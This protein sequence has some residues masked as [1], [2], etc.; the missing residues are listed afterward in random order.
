MPYFSELKQDVQNRDLSAL[1]SSLQSFPRRATNYVGSRISIRTSIPVRLCIELTNRCNLNCPFC[2]VGQQE[3]KESTAHHEL[4]RDMGGMD[5]ELC[6]KIHKFSKL[7]S[8]VRKIL[9]FFLFWF[10]FSIDPCRI[11]NSLIFNCLTFE[12]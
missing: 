12:C 1:I 2:L 7:R 9:F 8:L 6:K 10:R 4:D 5:F 11:C 3:S